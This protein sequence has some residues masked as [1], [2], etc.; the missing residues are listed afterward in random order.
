MGSTVAGIT[1]TSNKHREPID[2]TALNAIDYYCYQTNFDTAISY[3]KLYMWARFNNFQR[4]ISD[5]IVRHQVPDRVMICF[6]CIKRKKTSDR[7]QN[8]KL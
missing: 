7:T 5:T 8:A 1:D 3:A 6:N 2:Q 4:R